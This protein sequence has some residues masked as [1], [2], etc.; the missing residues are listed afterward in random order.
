MDLRVLVI[1]EAIHSDLIP[2][3]LQDCIQ[4]TGWLL[5]EEVDAAL[6][7]VDIF[8]MPSRY[9][10]FGLMAVEAQAAGTPVVAFATGGLKD[11]IQHE[12]SGLLVPPSE[13]HVGL[14]QQLL[15]FVAD[16]ELRRR[17]IEGG[18]KTAKLHDIEKIADEC[19][20]L[21]EP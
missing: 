20:R 3:N 1:G 4:V 17:C 14:A 19:L 5:P 12:R 15:R 7:C 8:L 9:E 11:I 2:T 13:G 10:A 21:Y 18:Y 16:P 6:K